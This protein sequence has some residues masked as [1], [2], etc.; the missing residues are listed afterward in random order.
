MNTEEYFALLEKRLDS[1]THEE[2][3]ERLDS[4]C[5]T[6][7]SIEDFLTYIESNLNSYVVNT[8]SFH[9]TFKAYFDAIQPGYFDCANDD[10]YAGESILELAA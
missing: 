8:E 7:P 4:Y 5:Q 6:G 9:K 2:T 10:E 3:M 1:Y